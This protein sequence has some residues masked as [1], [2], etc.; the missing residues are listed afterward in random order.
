MPHVINESDAHLIVV[1][2]EDLGD[3]PAG[4][5]Q[6]FRLTLRPYTDA[7]QAIDHRKKQPVW[8]G[9]GRFSWR[10]PAEVCCAT[11]DTVPRWLKWR[12]RNR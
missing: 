2:G 6:P 1:A 9:G 8:A 4:A 5:R 10:N 12:V 11:L 7:G 3:R